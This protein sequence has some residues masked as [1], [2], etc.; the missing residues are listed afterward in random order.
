MMMLPN[1]SEFIKKYITKRDNSFFEKDLL[2]NKEKLLKEIRDKSILVIGGAGTIGSS[3]IKA[4]LRF[5]PSKL[6]VV[7]TNE[8]GLT[9]LT[10]T[11]RSDFK[12]NVPNDYLTYPM[13]FNS[14]VFYKMLKKH[15]KFDVIANFAAHKH[16]RSEKDSFSVEAMIKNNVLDA[17]RFLDYLKLNKPSHF[18]CVSTDKAANP[19]NVMGG[20]KKM[21]ENVIMSYSKNLKITTARF[22]N[23][24]FSNGSLLYGYLERL[25]Q[26]Q[27]IS[28]PSDV[29][30]F[31]VSPEE[32]GEICLIT[33]ILGKSG[34][35]YFP[36]LN[37]DE[38]LNFKSITIDFF[39]Y[40]NKEIK[41]CKNE[42]E[43]KVFASQ[44]KDDSAYP[45]YFFET[46][47]SGE[48]LYEEF[49]TNDDQ[50][51]FNL[52]KSIGV[53]T[54]SIKSSYSEIDTAIK[55]LENLFKRGSYSKEDIIKVMNKIVPN[56]NHIETGKN[57]DDKM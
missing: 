7:D 49:Y 30:R 37:E 50:V 56:F 34:D 20:S 18:F 17:K 27:P 21:M 3:Y 36:K 12:I 16:V 45:V 43:A 41:I 2:N 54:N 23:V 35:I 32:S 51:N 9:E 40:L 22:A 14:D 44:M 11:L 57:L 42:K 24:A 13:S 25:I 28:C 48:K 55:E 33:S 15:G 39:K 5:F 19:V 4:A 8:N 38:M 31:F 52:Y 10:R 53:I 1:I 46:D 26:R 47:T 6:V 29:K